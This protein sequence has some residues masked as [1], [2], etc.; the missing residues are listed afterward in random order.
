MVSR[1]TKTRKSPTRALARALKF[2]N[3]R[4]LA[5]LASLLK[6][7]LTCYDIF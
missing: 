7:T 3:R 2:I 5:I 4:E 1:T 6:L